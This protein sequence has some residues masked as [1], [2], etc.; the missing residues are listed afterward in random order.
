MIWG[1][2][3]LSLLK[4]QDTGFYFNTSDPYEPTFYKTDRA[5]LGSIADEVRAKPD[6][7][8]FFTYMGSAVGTSP[9][10][11]IET[12]EDY[13]II[14]EFPED[15]P[16][17]LGVL[18]EQFSPHGLSIDWANDLIMTSDFVVPISILKPST[19]IQ[20]GNT[21]RLWKLSTREI[22]STITIPE[23]RAPIFH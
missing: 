20:R 1:G 9:G 17:V 5:L 12:D 19:Q 13:N 21:T 15:V 10:R 4:S 7:G 6:G 2:G 11:L 14:H 18:A 16:G 8:F 3:L 22:I 23:V